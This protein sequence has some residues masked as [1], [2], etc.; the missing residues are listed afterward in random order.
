[1]IGMWGMWGP[2]GG[3]LFSYG[4]EKVSIV[5]FMIKRNEVIRAAIH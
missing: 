1:M 5:D 3:G 4:G 2:G